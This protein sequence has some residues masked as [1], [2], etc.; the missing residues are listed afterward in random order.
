MS[1]VR[2]NII[3][4]RE[5]IQGTI[6]CSVADAVIASLSD[7]PETIAELEAALDRFCKRH[8]DC[9]P[10]AWFV[11]G[12]DTDPWDA[13]VIIVDLA[14]RIV[15]AESAN[16]A[17]QSQGEVNYHNGTDA[18]DFWLPYRLPDDWLFLT[19]VLE[20]QSV[21]SDRRAARM[22][23]PLLDVRQVLYGRPM[24]E[25][26]VSTCLAERE[27]GEGRA[28]DGGPSEH[29]GNSDFRHSRIRDLL[30]FGTSS[31]E[32]VSGASYR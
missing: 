20:Y 11:A 17:P 5:A 24:L 2:L 27:T 23:V 15:A 10:F 8:E 1:E 26:I 28:I 31:V 18:T 29:D 32:A 7:E 16:S 6:H 12:E 14:A 25:F 4:A 9:S 30:R 22:A 13:G 21:R 3:D 19:S